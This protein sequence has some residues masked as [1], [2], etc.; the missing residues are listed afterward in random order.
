MSHL[1]SDLSKTEES[2]TP[3]SSL[4]PPSLHGRGGG[5]SQTPG[6]PP[7]A[8]RGYVS[9]SPWSA[10]WGPRTRFQVSHYVGGGGRAGHRNAHVSRGDGVSAWRQFLAVELFVLGGWG[11]PIFFFIYLNRSQPYPPRSSNCDGHS[12]AFSGAKKKRRKRLKLAL[13][14]KNKLVGWDASRI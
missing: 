1:D 7:P 13:K 14:E 11:G 10:G 8:P 12:A 2:V 4:L 9:G 5:Q 3:S 6:V